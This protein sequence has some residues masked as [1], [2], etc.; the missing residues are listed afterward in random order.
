M[1]EIYVKMHLKGRVVYKSKLYIFK[2]NALTW[3]TVNIK[4]MVASG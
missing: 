3:D 2:G 4:R 1:I